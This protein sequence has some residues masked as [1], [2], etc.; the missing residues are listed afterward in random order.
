MKWRSVA[1]PL[2]FFRGQQIAC[3]GIV[4]LTIACERKPDLE[5]IPLSH[6]SFDQVETQM[7]RGGLTIDR[8]E[9]YSKSLHGKKVCWSGE[10]KQLDRQVAYVAV[11]GEFPNVELHLSPGTFQ[12]L[13]LGRSVT[14]TGL[15]ESV[16]LTHTS[17]PM[18]KAYVVLKYVEVT[19]EEQ[20]S[21]SRVDESKHNLKL[22]A[23]GQIAQ[24]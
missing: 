6:E 12:T 4:L 17:P 21:E 8:L 7:I 24:S 1:Y 18:P 11:Q 16:S 15:V 9:A 23:S 3:A 20:H 13:R 14:F 2:I 5:T 19:R 22:L 10:I